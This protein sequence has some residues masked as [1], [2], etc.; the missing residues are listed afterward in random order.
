[1]INHEVEA[2][3]KRITS[4]FERAMKSTG[5]YSDSQVRPRPAH[6]FR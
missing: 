5:L 1:M 4:L 3:A 6:F 2:Q